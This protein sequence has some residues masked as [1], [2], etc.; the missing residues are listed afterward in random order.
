MK[1]SFLV[2]EMA[3]TRA[4]RADDLRQHSLA[5]A[6]RDRLQPA[7]LAQALF[8]GVEQLI[9]QIALS[10]R[11]ARASVIAFGRSPWPYNRW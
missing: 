2:H 10:K 3:D 1:P 5:D 8:T 6:G 7:L 4:G 11:V 9:D